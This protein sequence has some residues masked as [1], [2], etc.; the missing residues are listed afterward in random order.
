L[1]DGGDDRNLLILTSHV[2]LDI[3]IFTVFQLVDESDD[4][5]HNG[6]ISHVFC[7]KVFA[8]LQSREHRA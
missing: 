5:P 7:Q 3:Q 6:T 4:V 1:S 8:Y 2:L